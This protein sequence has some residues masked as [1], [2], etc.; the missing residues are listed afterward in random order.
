[1]YRLFR[2]LIKTIFSYFCVFG[3]SSLITQLLV[4]RKEVIEITLSYAFSD[5]RI[6]KATWLLFFLLLFAMFLGE[7]TFSSKR[8]KS[9]DDKKNFSHLASVFEAKRGLT[10]LEFDSD[11]LKYPTVL[12]MLDIALDK[13]K[14]FYNSI[15]SFFKLDDRYKL[16]VRTSWKIND[17]KVYKRGGLVVY[18]P[19]FFKSRMYVDATDSHN[20]IIG[21]TNS[22][23][24]VSM[25]LQMIEAARMTGESLVVNDMKGELLEYT[26]KQLLDDDYDIVV[27]NFIEPECSDDWNP[28][29]GAWDAWYKNKKQYEEEM[30]LWEEK[31]KTL[32]A[33]ELRQHYMYQPQLDISDGIEY[34]K[35]VTDILTYE[36]KAS[37][38]FWNNSASDTLM[39]LFAFLMEEGNPD[40]IN[41]KSVQMLLNVAAEPLE[42]NMKK[43]YGFQASTKLG[44]YIEKTR[45]R[46]AVSRMRLQSFLESAEG[47]Q[48]SIRTVLAN[49]ISLL[50][51][52][53]KVMRLTS[54]STFDMK[55]LGR[56]KTAVFMVVH[57]EKNTYYPL[58]TL[59]VK[60]MYEAVIK[61]ARGN[62]GRLKV[63]VN[64]IIDEAGN[65]PPFKDVKAMLT[66]G[67]ARGTRFTFAFQDT[68]QIDDSYGKEVA[69]TIRN[70]CT[71]T[72][73]LLGS[74]ESTLKEF[75]DMC[76][77][78][79][80]WVPSRGF[81]ESRPI[82][83]TDRLRKMNL[84][85]VV[86]HRQRKNPFITRMVPYF[87]CKFYKGKN[88]DIHQKKDPKPN[89]V[90]FDLDYHFEK[91][92][93][94]LDE[95][96]N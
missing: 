93:K 79:Q 11:H 66:A 85:E 33:D 50:T 71:N 61:E 54:R 75:S 13:P 56:K 5:E 17:E 28:V 46:D 51:L 40:Y 16:N 81:Y 65:C 31:R 88:Y 48:K 78:Q 14:K 89:V 84:G 15:V 43:K 86:I 6:L 67:R 77:H 68:S 58:V 44:A 39:G 74:Q 3:L 2:F 94:Q 87:K 9:K 38:P 26:G 80:V 53:D 36:A 91:L 82:I 20:L 7:F 72:V 34:L 4:L 27:L 95:G 60:Q 30:K 70:N 62:S 29:Q 47:T 41:T 25:I 10:R 83:T 55:N 57:D 64:I 69:Q 42:K 12:D 23:K 8:K 21:T 37:D 59:F 76:G 35:D 90:Y 18:T 19:R 49:K 1:M 92:L 24:S 32:K 22:G 52:S 96:G 45:P 73:Y 63:P